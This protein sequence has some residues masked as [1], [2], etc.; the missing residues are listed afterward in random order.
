MKP[1]SNNPKINALGQ[2]NPSNKDILRMII[3]YLLIGLLVF[4][5]SFYCP[6][7]M[8]LWLIIGLAVS[9]LLYHY[10]HFTFLLSIGLIPFQQSITDAGFSIQI[11]VSDILLLAV[12]ISCLI[13]SP[14]L[15]LRGVKNIHISIWLFL[16]ISILSLYQCQHLGNG[17]LS[18]ARMALILAAAQ[19][20][21]GALLDKD[22]IFVKS[23]MLYLCSCVLLSLIMICLALTQG[24]ANAMY[25]LGIH[26]NA[27]G[28]IFACGII[29]SFPFCMSGRKS[30]QLAG[31]I[32]GSFCLAG[33]LLSMSR[34]AWFA[35]IVGF[36]F[37]L[38]RRIYI[39]LRWPLLTG[40]ILVV[41]F[42]MTMPASIRE[43]A[44]DISLS[45]PTVHDRL[46]TVGQNLELFIASP[47]IG[48]GLDVRRGLEPH[49]VLTLTI[50]E[51]GL[52]GLISFVWV[53]FNVWKYY[54]YQMRRY[55]SNQPEM[56]FLSICAS[57]FLIAIMHGM[58]DVYWRRG[59]ALLAWALYGAAR[60]RNTM[61]DHQP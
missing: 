23:S 13:K 16:L 28:P 12:F 9:L 38:T 36:T 4:S 58:V 50:A 20:A 24:M 49:N 60:A 1:S 53:L 52:L 35:F 39:K 6:L 8:Q 45:A 22:T 55:A 32:A 25:P 5:F 26:K 21:G 30:S 59:I 31:W 7:P 43:Y 19:A 44:Q 18:I 14:N 37:L 46:H 42:P 33:L 2:P 47:W 15:I 51:T 11:C 34:G 40:M 10:S 3:N 27:I 54:R 48:A 56:L 57:I 29:L 41:L 17:I 61:E